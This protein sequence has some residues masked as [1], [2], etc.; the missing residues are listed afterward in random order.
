MKAAA[1]MVTGNISGG[2][3]VQ[4]QRLEGFNDLPITPINN[5][6]DYV[7]KRNASSPL[8]EWVD[9]R[10]RDGASGYTV[11]GETKN[12]VDFDF[13]VEATKVQKI[14]AF[15]KVSREMLKDVSYV[16]SA[17]NEEL[18]AVVFDKLATEVLSGTGTATTINGITT[19]ATAY[20]AGGFALKVE[21][22]NTYD[23]LRTAITQITLAGYMPN[24]MVLNPADYGL[25]L[26]TKGTD[27][28]YVDGQ[29]LFMGIPVIQNAAL[30]ADKFLVYDRNAVELYMWE[31]FDIEIGYDGNDLTK[32][33]ITMVGELRACNVISTNKSAG[34]VYGTVSTAKT[35]LTKS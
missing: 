17:I 20:S 3:Y 1:P 7:S 14:T 6:L 16:Q 19:A 18:R 31:N 15:I 12:Q 24:V 30:T 11:E 8:I 10:N 5:I 21:T 13:V 23:V 22:P 29:F 35:A 27:A 26:M 28:T 32:N 25:M 4:A 9:K 33:M 2:D 34:I